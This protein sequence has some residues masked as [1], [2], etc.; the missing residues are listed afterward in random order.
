M[1]WCKLVIEIFKSLRMK[2]KKQRPNTSY[3][4][5]ERSFSPGSLIS[6]LPPPAFP[7]FQRVSAIYHSDRE[8]RDE[9]Q[10]SGHSKYEPGGFRFIFFT[11][12][13]SRVSARTHGSRCRIEINR[14]KSSPRYHL[15]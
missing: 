9:L 10:R 3:H 14:P 1:W 7:D 4:S 6:P 8:N 12:Q 11:S 13:E 15:Q 5:K 2:N